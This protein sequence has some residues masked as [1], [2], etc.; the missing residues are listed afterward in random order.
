MAIVLIPQ[1]IPNQL[2]R[3]NQWV[4]WKYSKTKDGKDTKLPINPQNKCLAKTNDPATW[5]AFVAAVVAAKNEKYPGVGFC[6]S[7]TDGITG[8]DLDHI[9]NP[10]TQELDAKAVEIVNKFLGTYIEIS[11]S[12]NGIRI[13]CFGKAKR[14][15]KCNGSDK[16]IEMYT[17]PS[18]RYL[19]VTGNHWSGSSK[20]ITQQQDALDWLYS[21]YFGSNTLDLSVTPSTA[22]ALPLPLLSHK[23]PLVK[24]KLS[25]EAQLIMDKM[26]NSAKSSDIKKLF[27]NDGLDCKDD[28]SNDLAFVNH[29]AF[30]CDKNPVLMDEI[31]RNSKRLR[32]KWDEKHF[33]DGRT[34]GQYTIDKAIKD[35]QASYTEYRKNTKDFSLTSKGNIRVTIA[36]A[37]IAL[38]KEYDAVGGITYNTFRQTIETTCTTAWGKPPGLWADKDTIALIIYLSSQYIEFPVT[39]IDSAVIHVAFQNSSNPAKEKLHSLA[40]EWDGVNRIDYWMRDYLNAKNSKDNE[41]YLKEISSAWIKGVAARVLFPGCKRDDCLVL[42]SSQGYGKSTAAQIIAETIY[43]E[44]FTDSLPPDL[45]TKDAKQA[46]HGKVIAEFSELASMKRS[47][48]ETIKAFISTVKDKFRPPYGKFEVEYPR[49]VSFIATTNDEHFLKDTTGNRRFWPVTLKSMIDM[50]ALRDIAPQLLGEAA[51]RVLDGENWWVT[52]TE[53]LSQANTSRDDAFLVDP[54][55][56]EILSTA[57]MIA[58]NNKPVT[59]HSIFKS[60][61]YDISQQT[62]SLQIRF[63]GVLKRAGWV[64]TRKQIDKQRTSVWTRPTDIIF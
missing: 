27:D 53:A 43:P 47:D 13:F 7:Q 58:D 15:G 61:E 37:V 50:D 52:H 44:G 33:S 36:N 59:M 64:S 3:L 25:K 60:L 40:R 51:R 5:E 4:C 16:Y 19:T 20:D 38:E 62:Q 54:L 22:S 24:N 39:T 46:L 28:S 31:F 34:Y 35:C 8:I 9:Y 45:S 26:L 63:S 18:S 57:V 11:P 2:T 48:I 29:L 10:E 17:F 41:V 6:L 14:S 1:N 30:W 55:E 42:V 21:T 12:G 32:M 56:Q 23:S 49:T